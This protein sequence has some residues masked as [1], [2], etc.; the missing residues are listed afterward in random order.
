M[1]R[2]DLVTYTGSLTHMHGTYRL[3]YGCGCL[4][5]VP[6]EISPLELAQERRWI[7]HLDWTGEGFA[8]CDSPEVLTCVRERHI[9]PASA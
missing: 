8:P 6:E 1:N 4:N 5:C 9:H 3:G 2:G 7:L